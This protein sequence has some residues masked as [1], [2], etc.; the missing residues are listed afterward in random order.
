[1]I[2]PMDP[3][4]TA[5]EHP[6]VQQYAKHVNP[7][8]VKLLG[9]LGYGRLL[10]RAKDVWVWDHAGREYLDLLACFGAVNIGH[11]HPRLV[12]RLQ[13]YLEED[14]LQF[15]H[16]GPSPHAAAL[17]ARL[18]ALASPGLEV[19]LLSSTG[20]EA[21]EAGMKVARAATGRAGFVSC[22]GGYHGTSL[23]TLSIM[24]SPRMR[25][26]FEPLLAQCTT[27]P[28]G[29][30][31][32]LD[33]AL[34]SKT[35]A[36][37]VVDPFNCEV[38]AAPPPPG[39]LAEA[40]ALCRR[41]GSLLVLDEVQ[42]GLGRTGTLFAYQAPAPAGG[43]VPDVLVLAKSLSGGFAPIGA[44]LISAALQERAYGSMDRFDLHNSTFG[45]NGLSC[46]AALETLDILEQQG[47]V[48]ASAERGAELLA[49]VRARLEGHP[50]VRSVR[51]R[52]LLV[53]VELGP[54][55]QGWLNRLAPGLV[56]AVS[57]QVFGQWA[58][59]KLLERGVI[60]QP[61]TQHWDVLKLEPPL[62]LQSREVDQ[63]VA[64]LGDVLDEYRGVSALVNDVV[65]RVGKQFMAGW[66]F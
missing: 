11:N 20:A 62:T 29:D 59:V 37:F 30:L 22:V 12:R 25:G 13:R 33:A 1:M 4:T 28:F 24:G 61:A 42:T 9:V 17:A 43:F 40:Q 60:A 44:T 35:V 50:L 47:L 18:A 34:R 48:A 7:A 53:S 63:A 10:T 14:A 16:V 21:V 5:R 32:A 38:S 55:E 58:A 15:V 46:A 45:G 26:P 6:A 41:Y 31:G 19:A 51:G 23:G 2:A 52:G 56:R 64:A 3:T 66:G 57:K 54:T 49:K 65:E 39:Y 36:A 8:F 27:V